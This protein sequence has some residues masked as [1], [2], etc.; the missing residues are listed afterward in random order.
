M[1]VVGGN[2]S[3]GE[4]DSEKAAVTDMMMRGIVRWRW[5]GGRVRLRK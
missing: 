1:L 3:G 5:L 4:K 2:E